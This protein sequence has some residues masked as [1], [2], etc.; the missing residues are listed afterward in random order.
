MIYYWFRIFLIFISRNFKKKINPEEELTR[1]FRV[2]LLDC[3]G[4][5]IMTAYKYVIYMD[6]IRWEM[7]LRSKLFKL[8]VLKGLA[9]ALSSQKL[10]YKKPIK[11]FT[12]FTIKLKTVGWDNKW[13]YHVHKFEQNGKIKAIGVTKALLWKKNKQQ[14]L[15]KVLMG[16]DINE[17][18]KKPPEWV[19]NLFKND[20]RIHTL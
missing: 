13:V 15:H 7:I 2:R 6:L 10:V 18:N 3:D 5:R 4:L 20:M 14:N 8:I 11:R 19:L 9:P 1:T 16:S 12:K 17:F